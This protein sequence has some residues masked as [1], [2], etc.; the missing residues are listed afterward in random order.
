MNSRRS[1]GRQCGGAGS[2]ILFVGDA[3]ERTSHVG[4]RLCCGS[5]GRFSVHLAIWLMRAW[6]ATLRRCDGSSVYVCDCWRVNYSAHR[7]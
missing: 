7:Q 5:H 6:T 1:I 2:S 3:A 4:V